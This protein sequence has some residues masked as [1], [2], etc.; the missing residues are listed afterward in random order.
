MA[1]AFFPHEI[2]DPD[3]EWLVTTFLY[4]KPNYI[5][6]EVSDVPLALIPI[7]DEMEKAEAPQAKPDSTLR[8]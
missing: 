7:S 5:P 6:V 2:E 3:L 1:R 4:D 8:K